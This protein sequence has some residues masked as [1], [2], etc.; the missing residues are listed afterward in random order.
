MKKLIIALLS[1]LLIAFFCA[2]TEE[3]NEVSKEFS[4][5]KTESA[6][7]SE[8]GSASDLES[9]NAV[10]DEPSDKSDPESSNPVFNNSSDNQNNDQSGD[11]SENS[12]GDVSGNNGGDN[13]GN[14]GGW[15]DKDD[16]NGNNGDDD[17][18]IFNDIGDAELLPTG[19]LI[20]NGAAYTQTSYDAT[21]CERYANVYDKYAKLFPDTRARRL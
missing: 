13:S 19:Y 2:C 18:P 10:S 1:L 8:N 9:S 3:M 4:E 12:N 21:N 5:N 7:S 15:F 11:N 17:K 6:V 20:Y 14:N 16:N